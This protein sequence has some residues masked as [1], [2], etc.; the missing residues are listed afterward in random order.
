MPLNKKHIV[1]VVNNFWGQL[2]ASSNPLNSRHHRALICIVFIA[3]A[4]VMLLLY[5]SH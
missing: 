3:N 2:D 1:D 4:I 5:D